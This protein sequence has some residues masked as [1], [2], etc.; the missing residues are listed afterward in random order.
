MPTYDYRCEAN[1]QIY[2]VRHAMSENIST[3]GELCQ[4][5]NL[6]PEDI[7]FDTPVKK[8]ISTGGVVRSESLKNPEAPPCMTGQG[9][10]GD[11][12]GI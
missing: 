12:C 1:E 7:A 3:W 5:G 4:L 8:V 6:E 9:C 2:E 11:G 10:S